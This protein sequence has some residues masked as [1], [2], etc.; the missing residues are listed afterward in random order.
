[1]LGTL[2]IEK[3]R[4]KSQTRY[5]SIQKFFKRAFFLVVASR[6]RHAPDEITFT[7]DACEGLTQ[8]PKMFRKMALKTIIKGAK[9]EG[10]TEINAEFA[11]KFKP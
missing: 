2:L 8:A 6:A 9:E 5:S 10:I 1:V 3:A 7:D 11:D 4:S